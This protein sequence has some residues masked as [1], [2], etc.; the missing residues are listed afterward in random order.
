MITIYD[1]SELCGI[2]ITMYPAESA[3]VI[4]TFN[5]LEA[6]YDPVI[7]KPGVDGA[8]GKGV[9]NRKTGCVEIDVASTCLNYFH[10]PYL[11]EQIECVRSHLPEGA[12]VLCIGQSMGS[13]G[14]ML[15][16]NAL[17]CDF[18]AFGTR[19][20]KLPKFPR[21]KLIKSLLSDSYTPEQLREI[22]NIQDQI[23]NWWRDA[24]F[25]HDWSRS[26]CLYDPYHLDDGIYIDRENADK[27]VEMFKC[28][29]FRCPYGT[30]PAIMYINQ[31]YGLTRLAEDY[32]AGG[33]YARR[34]ATFPEPAK[35]PARRVALCCSSNA[36]LRS[37]FVHYLDESKDDS[38][39]YRQFSV[40]DVSSIAPVLTCLE[41]NIPDEY[42]VCVVDTPLNDII[43]LE[44]NEL[45][46][47]F[48]I[49]AVYALITMF[50][51]KRCKLVFLLHAPQHHA[52]CQKYNPAL[53]LLR[54]YADQVTLV[55]YTSHRFLNYAEANYQD[56]THYNT[57]MQYQI[58]KHLKTVL[59]DGEHLPNVRLALSGKP[60][61]GIPRFAALRDIP[62][63]KDKFT[64][65]RETSLIKSVNWPLGADDEIAVRA[66]DL[67]FGAAPGKLALLA[68]KYWNTTRTG[69]LYCRPDGREG[70]GAVLLQKKFLDRIALS[71]VKRTFEKDVVFAFK[72]AAGPFRKV[73]NGAELAAPPAR[74]E[75][76]LTD[77]LFSDTDLEELGGSIADRFGVPRYFRHYRELAAEYRETGDYHCFDIFE[78]F[79]F[80]RS[81][82]AL[83]PS[84]LEQV[85]F[86][87]WCV[88][89]TESLR[90]E[91]LE[92][93]GDIYRDDKK[94]ANAELAYLDA[95]K[96]LYGGDLS[97]LYLKLTALYIFHTREFE[98]ARDWLGRVSELT[99]GNVRENWVFC[100]HAFL[101]ARHFGDNLE[102][103]W[104]GRKMCEMKPENK[105]WR[106]EYL[107]FRRT[108]GVRALGAALP[109]LL[110]AEPPA[111]PAPAAPAAPAAKRP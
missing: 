15:F 4:I 69:A 88:V 110:P 57:V 18:Y 46:E 38:C 10:T 99:I 42:D 73:H 89:H 39:E 56:M 75:L 105:S 111:A 98:K 25:D 86:L 13:H 106:D 49:G 68:V 32:F 37:G 64:E 66:E 23:R 9:Y 2:R 103:L 16:A 41:N 54:R 60:S 7:P 104:Y 61:F 20:H 76:L 51:E 27:A 19:F 72:G 91:I 47:E 28:G 30:H 109:D 31:V 59:S 45:T 67:N 3:N 21:D 65:R 78:S 35:R 40:G 77:M 95:V 71:Y 107:E 58:A 14:A 108:L 80:I 5:Y 74:P 29:V 85:T 11:Q 43:F 36:I 33:A 52:N 62:R 100:R 6:D 92:R 53:A 81:F 82:Q 96:Y 50:D 8:W 90:S 70:D 63:F 22:R 48:V 24:E 93:L 83:L 97:K 34:I 17:K 101:I 44:R 87:D 1:K 12:K 102:A 79:H 26:L 55:D 94:P 84:K